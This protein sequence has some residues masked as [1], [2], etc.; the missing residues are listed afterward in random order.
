MTRVAVEPAAGAD[1]RR[2]G[3]ERLPVPEGVR[4]G[5]PA[6]RE[7]RM[8]RRAA[9]EQPGL[10]IL[11]RRAR[12]R[13]SANPTLGA[14]CST[15]S[16]ASTPPTTGA[17]GGDRAPRLGQGGRQRGGAG[18]Q[19]RPLATPA[20]PVPRVRPDGAPGR[21][22]GAR[23]DGAATC[24]GSA[25]VLVGTSIAGAIASLLA[26][27]LWAR[28][29]TKPIYELRGAGP[30]GGR[31][32]AHPGRARARGVEALGD[33]VGA[34]VEKLEETDAALAEHRRR[35]MQSEKLSAVGELAAKLAHEVL[36]PLAGMKAAVQLLARQG[37]RGARRRRGRR[38]RRGAEPRD[39]ARRGAG[40]PAG[41]TTRAR[42]R[43]ASRSRRSGRCWTRRSRPPSRR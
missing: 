23:R 34:L 8:A 35:L 2:R 31:A 36:N 14:S 9:D 16:S 24:A 25:I 21:R 22:A 41:R 39:H 27:F 18:G 32:N 38:H 11:A 5:I 3:D 13:R 15:T 26:G 33:Q 10:R 17:K 19:P 20:R 42:S 6:E 4:R 30:I 1:R 37:A 12:T 29:I 40:P 28:R 43:R 7:P